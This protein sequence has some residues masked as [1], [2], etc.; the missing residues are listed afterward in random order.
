MKSETLKKVAEEGIEILNEYE[1]RKVLDE[2]GIPCPKEIMIEYE[3]GKEGESYL[4]E[5]KENGG[6]PEYP[7]FLKIVS[8]DITSKTD[9]GGIKRVSSDK[10]AVNAI[11]EIIENVKE[12]ESEAEIQGILAS[13]DASNGTREMIL[14]STVDSQFG[15]V[16]SIGVGGI[17]VEVYKDVEFRIVPLEEADVYSMIENLEGKEILGE[18]RGMK[19]VDMDS[20]VETVLKFSNMIEE[21]P[22]IREIDVNPLLVSSDRTIAVD[23]LLRLSPK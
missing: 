6:M 2:Y 14:G 10:E 18:F 15:H 20:F 8:R 1:A 4:R 5:F 11:D 9:A 19:A 23:T 12:Y 21:N 17:Y 7:I 13:E 3:E 16:I 22:E